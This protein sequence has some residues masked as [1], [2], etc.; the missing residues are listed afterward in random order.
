MTMQSLWLSCLISVVG[1]GAVGAAPITWSSGT[2][3]NNHS[4]DVVFGVLTWTQARDAA[5]ALNLNGAQGYLVT[6]T[7]QAENDFLTS[8]FA[9]SS[10]S[11]ASA[12][13]GAA[14]LAVES[15]WRWVTG[16]EAGTQFWQG[17]Q[18]TGSTTAPFNFAKW[19]RSEPNNHN[20]G[21]PNAED[22]GVFALRT[23]GPTIAFGEWGDADD[24]GTNASIVGYLVEYDTPAVPEPSGLALALTAL[25]IVPRC[26]PDRKRRA[27]GGR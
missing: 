18:F 20:T 26:L 2:G 11:P 12:W 24:L 16:P 4:Y 25:A 10:G 7:S 3:A 13:I 1:A 5:A 6:I 9:A 19:G 14:D 27:R 15:E 22:F 21:G 8:N 23:L 17:D